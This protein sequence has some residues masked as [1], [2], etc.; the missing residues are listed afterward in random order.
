VIRDKIAI[1][2]KTIKQG[3]PRP[4][5]MLDHA[6]V[7]P[8]LEMVPGSFEAS[9]GIPMYPI[10][11]IGGGNAEKDPKIVNYVST[12]LEEGIRWLERVTRR[13]FSD[14]L[15]IKAARNEIKVLVL[16]GNIC[17]LTWRPRAPR[18]ATAYRSVPTRRGGQDNG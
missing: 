5:V 17:A 9:G 16:W 13:E 7:Q 12:R 6:P 4:D 15:F 14:E 1:T 18:R 8:A 2:D 11:M 3:Y 10:D